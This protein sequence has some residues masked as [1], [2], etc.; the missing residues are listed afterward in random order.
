EAVPT[1]SVADVVAVRGVDRTDADPEG[2]QNLSDLLDEVV[3]GHHDL[4]GA[5]GGDVAVGVHE[6]LDQRETLAPRG[7]EVLRGDVLVAEQS[8]KAELS[9]EAA[10]RELDR[11][12]R[13]GLHLVAVLADAVEDPLVDGGDLGALAGAVAEPSSQ[14]VRGDR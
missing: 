14:R 5:V 9:V 11:A 6:P 12:G 3:V 4:A 13:E 2:A 1:R 7:A 10:D 8:G